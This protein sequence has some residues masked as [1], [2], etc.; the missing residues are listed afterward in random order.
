MGKKK[1]TFADKVSKGTGPR[2]EVCPECETVKR[3]IKI[4]RA[5]Q[6]DSKGSWRFSEKME[7]VCKCNETELMGS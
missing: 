2:G 3:V 6:D 4:I 5:E 7:K 1:R